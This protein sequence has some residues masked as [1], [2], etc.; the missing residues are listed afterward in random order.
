MIHNQLCHIRRLRKL[1]LILGFRPEHRPE[2]NCDYDLR[3]EGQ[4][5]EEG[6]PFPECPRRI[7]IL[8]SST[9]MECDARDLEEPGKGSAPDG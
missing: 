3:D 8:H 2:H 5:E 7:N 6:V 4:V 9:I 1:R